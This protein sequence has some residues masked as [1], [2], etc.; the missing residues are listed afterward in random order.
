[1]MEIAQKMLDGGAQCVG[2]AIILR[3]KQLGTMVNGQI[4]LTKHGK[5][6]LAT[7]E[8]VDGAS[9]KAQQPV[10]EIPPVSKSKSKT[11]PTDTPKSESLSVDDILKD[12]G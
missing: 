3:Q 11:K 9:I 5:D 7:N 8:Q 4:M 1:M 2:G 10:D 6:W 12:I